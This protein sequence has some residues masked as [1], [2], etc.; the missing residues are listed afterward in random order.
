MNEPP[1]S[2]KALTLLAV[3]VIVML[4]MALAMGARTFVI[5]M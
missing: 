5:G 3:L 2:W 4:F 1:P